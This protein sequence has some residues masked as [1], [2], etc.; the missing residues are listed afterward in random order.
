MEATTSASTGETSMPTTNPDG[1]TTATPGGG[2]LLLFAADARKMVLDRFGSPSIIQKIEYNYDDKDPLY[3]GEALKEN[4]LVV[5]ELSATSGKFMKWDV[6]Y[7]D[8]SW[9]D[10]ADQLGSMISMDKA[11]FLVI[12][13]S[14]VDETFVQK[15]EF[16]W[17]EV[18]P[19]YKGEAFSQGYKYQFEIEAF[20]G[21]FYKWE[22]DGDD[23]TWKDQ[24]YNVR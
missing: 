5:F 20:G 1:V 19:L 4:E 22:V 6:D 3:K 2:T 13:R 9:Y 7:D 24:Y 10:F 11:A 21:N 23:D 14:G 8:D 17:D 12:E 15:I 18:Q 16:D